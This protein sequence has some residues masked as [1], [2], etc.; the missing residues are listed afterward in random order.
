MS[1]H[2]RVYNELQKLLAQG[3]PTEESLNGIF[4]FLVHYRCLLLGNT[5]ALREGNRVLSGPFAGMAFVDP[6]NG[7]YAP[8]LLGCYEQ[9]LHD[10]VRG[11]PAAGYERVINIGCGE[12]YYAVGIKRLHPAIQMWAHDIDPRLQQKCR[13]MAALNGVGIA[14]GGAFD[15]NDFATHADH[16]TL[17]WC[18]IEGHEDVLLDPVRHPAL[19]AMDILAELHPTDQGHLVERIPARFAA[20]HRVEVIRPRGHVFPMPDWLRDGSQINQLLVQFEW[21]GVATPWAMM[22]SRSLDRVLNRAA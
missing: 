15:P 21:R 10:I 11:I 3:Q 9:E 8:L 19:A 1:I 4:E 17:V 20:T 12:G 6:G 13:D 18:D 5:I 7:N 14:V 2:E 16:K 22:H